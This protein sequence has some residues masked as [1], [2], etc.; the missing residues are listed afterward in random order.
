MEILALVTGYVVVILISLVGLLVL[1]RIAT[2]KIDL[3]LLLS[4]KD[5]AAS[6]S[7]FQMFIFTF[8]VAMCV[9]V[10]TLESGQFPKLGTDILGLLGI[11]AATYGVSKGIQASAEE[12]ERRDAT[13]NQVLK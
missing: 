10:L 11:S 9:L 3:K 1:W 2:N 12:K 4:E 13:K 5:G 7:R 6:F 8:V